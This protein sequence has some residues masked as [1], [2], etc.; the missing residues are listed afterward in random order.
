MDEAILPDLRLGTTATA[1]DL[2][3]RAVVLADGDEVPFDDVVIAT[4]ATPRTLPG[5]ESLPGVHVLRTIDDCIALRDELDRSPAVA[6][7][8]AGFIGSEVAA[9]CRRRGLDVTVIEALDLP[10]IRI[11]GPEIGAVCADVHRDNGTAL[12]LG[13]GVAGIE[14][15][16][17][18]ERVRLADGS[19]VEADVVVVGIGVA[20]ATAWL[21]G[22][23]LTLDNGVVCDHQLRAAPGVFAVGDCARWHNQTFGTSMRVEHWT[24]AASA[25]DHVAKTLLGIDD[26]SYAPVPYY[27]SDQYDRKLQFVGHVSGGETVK[28][29]EG[30]T[31]DRKFAATYVRDGVVV[32][33]LTM[34]M[35]ARIVHYE[36][37]VGHPFEG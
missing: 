16:G 22:S 6:V 10:L 27:W 35:P 3:R 13:V 34:N 26:E 37:L 9:A 36:Q 14:G 2:G 7:I 33:A 23:G 15:D 11:L 20:P 19:A 28:V 29:V 31:D 12:R 24:N 21:E 8:G 30:S 25:G 4:G 18:A 32:A 1:L 5:T 17:R